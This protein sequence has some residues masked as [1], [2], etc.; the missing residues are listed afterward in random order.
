MIAEGGSSWVEANQRHLRVALDAVRRALAR[1]AGEQEPGP[2]EQPLPSPGD[3]AE[4]FAL[5]AACAA[6]DLSPFERD[7]L[8]LCAGVELDGQFA[9]LCGAAHGDPAK[10]YPTFGLALA[11]WAEPHW[12][13]VTPEAPLRQSRLIEVTAG[14]PLTAA[15]LRIAE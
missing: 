15:P 7:I 1:H 2:T 9:A 13:A 12:S 5:D 6:F 4:P 8:I 11:A 3:A 14:Y 10:A